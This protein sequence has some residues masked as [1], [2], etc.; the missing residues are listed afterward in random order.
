M[1]ARHYSWT[2]FNTFGGVVISFVGN[3]FIARQLTPEDYGLMAML[4]IF[5]AIAMNFTES[6]FSDYLISTPEVDKKDYSTVF[7]HNIFV[8]LLFYGL[9]VLFSEE[10]ASFYQHKEL[11]GIV[12]VAGLGIV[13]KSASLAEMAK[14]RKHLEFKKI[15]LVTLTANLLSIAAA[16]VLALE[17]YGYWA[18][19]FQIV[20]QAGFILVLVIV[21]NRWLPDFS[22]SL[23]RYKKMR[24]FGNNMLASYLSNQLADNLYTVVIGKL[25]SA[26]SLGFYAQAQKISMVAFRGLNS[27]VLTTSYSL[28]AKERDPLKR[29]EMYQRVLSQFLFVHFCFSFFVIG[30]ASSLII[31]VYGEKWS[32]SILF[33]QLMILALLFQPLVTVNANIAK[34]ENKTNVY[35]NLAFFRNGII[36]FALLI[37][38]RFSIEIMLLGQIAAKYISAIVD[39]FVCGRYARFYTNEQLKVVINNL[40][41][42]ISA[43]SL[44][45][46]SVTALNENWLQ[47]ISFSGVYLLVFLLV[48]IFL[49]NSTLYFYLNKLRRRFGNGL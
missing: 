41:A 31:L 43:F 15:A 30:S 48:A 10:I 33:L 26:I 4:A 16:Y 27:I 37:T 25:Y 6:G 29:K 21:I 47:L 18:L 2:A 39:V 19:V 36:F 17:G 11:V 12:Q 40:I 5:I 1:A 7:F 49:R 38:Y 14:M 46:W 3:V 32:G 28:V 45:A 13:L 35:R 23:T 9:L 34:V 22:F 44:A 8:G 20:F 42:P 24:G